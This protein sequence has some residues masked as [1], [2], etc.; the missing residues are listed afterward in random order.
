[1]IVVSGGEIVLIKVQARVMTRLPP[2]MVLYMYLNWFLAGWLVLVVVVPVM[3][4]SYVR[5]YT[6]SVVTL[7]AS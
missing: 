4:E 1:M 2:F 3:R 6:I 5:A 7:D